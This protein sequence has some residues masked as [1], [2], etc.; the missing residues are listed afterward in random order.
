[1]G[2]EVVAEH[3]IDGSPALDRDI[4]WLYRECLRDHEMWGG[5]TIAVGQDVGE[6]F[7]QRARLFPAAPPHLKRK[8]VHPPVQQSAV[9][10]ELAIE[11]I[12]DAPPS[13]Q[14]VDGDLVNGPDEL[15]V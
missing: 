9:I 2:E 5:F 1:M 8:Q 15:W 10:G 11:F 14:F 7:D 12:A 4:R 3:S 6:R 13:P